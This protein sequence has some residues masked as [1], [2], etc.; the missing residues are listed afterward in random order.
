[1]RAETGTARPKCRAIASPSVGTRSARLARPDA[2]HHEAEHYA[3]NTL[4]EDRAASPPIKRNARRERR[5][6]DAHAKTNIPIGPRIMDTGTGR[7]VAGSA[8]YPR[9]QNEAAS[10]DADQA[11][12]GHR[13]D[14]PNQCAK[15]ISPRLGEVR[16]APPHQ[17]AGGGASGDADGRRRKQVTSCPLTP[18]RQCGGGQDEDR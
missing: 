2:G 16:P 15:R 5:G 13:D 12:P 1:M 9:R 17:T 6:R 3:V 7:A 18:A 4:T 8:A 10:N 14:L 11:D